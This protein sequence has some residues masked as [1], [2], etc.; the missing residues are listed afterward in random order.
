MTRAARGAENRPR[1]AVA[2][3][4][5]ARRRLIMRLRQT[6]SSIRAERQPGVSPG[7]TVR[8]NSEAPC[9]LL[10]PADGAASSGGPFFV[11]PR[12]SLPSLRQGTQAREAF[13]RHRPPPRNHGGFAH[14]RNRLP[15]GSSSRVSRRSRPIR[16]RKPMRSSMRSS[17]AISRICV[18]NSA[19]SCC[20]SSFTPG[21]RRR[22]G[23]S[24]SAAWS[25]R[26]PPS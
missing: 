21:S 18:T 26:S 8:P 24:T 22:P 17:A 2:A 5:D 12:P 16:S 14:A 13:P 19:I 23:A 15:L 7:R 3:A 10:K 25:R 4:P 20:R 9:R 11:C 1:P 6:G